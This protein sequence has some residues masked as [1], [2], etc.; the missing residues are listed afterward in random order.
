MKSQ[1]AS[2]AGIIAPPKETFRLS[3]RQKNLLYAMARKRLLMKLN[4]VF[5]LFSLGCWSIPVKSVTFAYV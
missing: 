4:E 1:F 5:L 3:H 2:K